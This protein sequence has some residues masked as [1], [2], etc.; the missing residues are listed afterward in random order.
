MLFWYVIKKSKKTSNDAG[1]R[2]FYPKKMMR[3][4]S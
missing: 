1:C 3:F 2:P 4:I